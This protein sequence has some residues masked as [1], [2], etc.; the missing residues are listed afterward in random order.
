ME[1]QL[2]SNLVKRKEELEQLLN[3]LQENQQNIDHSETK[4]GLKS[5]QNNI[6]EI[7]KQLEDTN[8]NIGKYKAKIL[9]LKDKIDKIKQNEEQSNKSLQT[10]SESMEKLLN[11]HSLLQQKKQEAERKIREIGTLP[12][13]EYE[14]FKDKPSK[15]L[16]KLL[17]ETQASLK[18]YSHVNKKAFDQYKYFIERRDEL[19][20]RTKELDEAKQSIQALIKHLDNQKEDTLKLT[21]QN[22]G[23]RFAEVFKELTD[24]EG[25]GSIFYSGNPEK[26]GL[27]LTVKF[28]DTDREHRLTEG[29][30]SLSHGQRSL[31]ALAFIFAI[32]RMDVSPFYIFD[33]I[34]AA[35][36]TKYAHNIAEYIKNASDSFNPVTKKKEKTQFIVISFKSEIPKIANKHYLVKLIGKA[37]SISPI[38]KEEALAFIEETHQTTIDDQMESEDS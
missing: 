29:Q 3:P 21:I 38:T 27:A 19:N 15:E 28:S 13:N 2:Y 8:S 18:E 33:E 4:A 32:Q 17:Q 24:G 26:P 30:T 12:T 1:N 16:A 34:D 25:T 10:E 36:D 23:Y 20:S 7:E 5:I 22:V 35:L 6:N 9:E 14:Q 11:Q 31:V 37:S